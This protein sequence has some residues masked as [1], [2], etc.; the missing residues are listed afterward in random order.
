MKLGIVGG[1]AMGEVILSGA[2]N[3]GLS[4]PGDVC[5]GELKPERGSYLAGRYGVSTT[6]DNRLAV[7]GA[8]MIV[9]AVKPQVMTAVTAGLKEFLEDGQL[10]MSVAAG[11]RLNSLC[12]GLDHRAVVWVM[13]NTPAQLG[14][15]M[16][17]WTATAEVTGSQRAMVADVL[18]AL[19]RELYVD[20]ERYLDMATA[21]SGSGPAYFF[22]MV[23]AMITAAENIGL[24]PD[25]AVSLVI[26]TA[27]GAAA[28]M[29]ESGQTPAELRRMVTSPGGTTAAALKQ[30][31]AGDYSGI[32]ERAV[33]AA[34]TRAQ[35][36]GG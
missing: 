26:Q 27:V 13:P 22:Y 32:I 1:G 11:I 20:D 9:L 28:M 19:G 31:E 35:E 6:D 36:L 14:Q 23:E 3:K 4:S 25:V 10:V 5:V 17:V 8:E 21:V 34:F 30:L 12:L 2:L 33:R 18:E 24:P 15:G 29:N 7:K 16:S